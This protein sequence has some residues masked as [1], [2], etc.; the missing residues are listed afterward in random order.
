VENSYKLTIVPKL[1]KCNTNES[2]NGR[3]RGCG[4]IPEYDKRGVFCG[5]VICCVEDGSKAKA[6]GVFLDL[7][8]DGVM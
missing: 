7:C 4:C 1:S 6:H 2:L 3:G 5:S 8:L